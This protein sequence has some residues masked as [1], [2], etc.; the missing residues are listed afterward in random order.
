M[1]GD[2]TTPLNTPPKDYGGGDDAA[3]RIPAVEGGCACFA[4]ERHLKWVMLALCCMAPYG[5]YYVFD[6]PGTIG[7]G[8]HRTIQTYFNDAGKPYTTSMNLLFYS[9]YSWP[10]IILSFFWGVIMEKY[11]GLRRSMAIGGAIILVSSALFYVGLLLTSFPL[12]LASRVIYGLGGESMT[13]GQGAFV[14]R[15]FAEGGGVAFAFGLTVTFLSLSSA[16]TFFFSP[17][18]AQ[19]I[20]VPAAV[21]TGVFVNAVSYAATLGLNA[22][23]VYGERRGIVPPESKEANANVGLRDV[24]TMPPQLW[25]LGGSSLFLYGALYPFIGVAKVFVEV[26][27]GLHSVDAA[28]AVAIYQVFAAFGA[29]VIGALVDRTG[30]CAQWLLLASTMF[31]GVHLLVRFSDIAIEAL[32]VFLGLAYSIMVSSLWPAV[33]FAVEGAQNVAV[34]FGFL[35]TTLSVGLAIFP[36]PVGRILDAHTPPNPPCNRTAATATANGTH[37][38]P[39]SPPSLEGFYAAEYVFLGGMGCAVLCAVALAVVDRLRQSGGLLLVSPSVRVAMEEAR[40]AAEGD[41]TPDT[42]TDADGGEE[43]LLLQ[44]DD[45]DAGGVPSKVHSRANSSRRRANDDT[46]DRLPHVAPSVDYGDGGDQINGGMRRRRSGSDSR[47]HSGEVTPRAHL[48]RHSSGL[49]ADAIAPHAPRGRAHTRS[50]PPTPPT[51]PAPMPAD[52]FR[53]SSFE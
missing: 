45:G 33:P 16:S 25:L 40:K 50:L 24:L 5:T 9:V 48:R 20:S 32:M 47:S 38:P 1:S 23:D 44:H 37:C 46:T 10:N 34:A 29:P 17:L 13:V 15:W 21:L 43:G 30:R 42:V 41:Q 36:L 27:Y 49:S 6:F 35:T 51:A 26:K 19:N 8:E 18:I 39:P 2:E 52:A 22:I 3:T 12:M 53:P 28:R 11:L 14:A 4:A 31:V 7:T